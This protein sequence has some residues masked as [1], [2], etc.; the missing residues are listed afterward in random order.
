MRADEFTAQYYCVINSVDF[1]H[2]SSRRPHDGL[3]ALVSRVQHFGQS[4]EVAPG[5]RTRT[6]AGIGKPTH[7]TWAPAYSEK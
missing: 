6:Q 3:V 4:V 1:W 5:R 2:V 7:F